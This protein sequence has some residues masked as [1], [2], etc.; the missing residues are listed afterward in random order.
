MKLHKE[1]N[2]V[3]SPGYDIDTILDTGVYS[4][5]MYGNN[6]FYNIEPATLVVFSIAESVP[7]QFIFGN[8]TGK[9]YRRHATGSGFS[10]WKEI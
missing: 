1:L 10:Q 8:S 4:G 3:T 6:P 5:Y 9:A 7:I 2:I